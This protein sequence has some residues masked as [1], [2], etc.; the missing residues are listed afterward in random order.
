MESHFQ[1]LIQ[2]PTSTLKHEMYKHAHLMQAYKSF[3]LVCTSCERLPHQPYLQVERSQYCSCVAV[4]N[5]TPR[6]LPEYPVSSLD[7]TPEPSIEQ[8][9]PSMIR[10]QET[11]C[12]GPTRSHKLLDPPKSP[13]ESPRSLCVAASGSARKR[14]LWSHALFSGSKWGSHLFVGTMMDITWTGRFGL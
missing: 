11:E 6:S 12:F 3:Q 10:A 7:M 1:R 9:M 14:R 5:C 4:Y 13:L 8:F 2:Q